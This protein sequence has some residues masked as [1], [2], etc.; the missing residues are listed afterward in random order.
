MFPLRDYSEPEL[1]AL[2]AD[3][4]LLFAD[5]LADGLLVYDAPPAPRAFAP[6][7][8]R[9]L[10]SRAS[11]SQAQLTSALSRVRALRCISH[12]LST[13]SLYPTTDQQHHV[14]RFLWE[15]ANN[16]SFPAAAAATLFQRNVFIISMPAALFDFLTS[17]TW[18]QL[19]HA[20]LFVLAHLAADAHGLDI[21]HEE[22]AP[23]LAAKL[24]GGF[25]SNG[26]SEGCEPHVFRLLLDLVM[27]RIVWMGP[28][29]V[30]TTLCY[31][32]ASDMTDLLAER[33]ERPI[34]STPEKFE[35][36]HTMMWNIYRD[37]QTYH[38]ILVKEGG[39]SR[40]EAL[41]LM[42]RTI[43]K[44]TQSLVD[45]GIR[46][47]LQMTTTEH[48]WD[49]IPFRYEGP[50][51]TYPGPECMYPLPHRLLGMSHLSRVPED[52][53]LRLLLPKLCEAYAS[54]ETLRRRAPISPPVVEANG[55]TPSSVAVPFSLKFWVLEDHNLLRFY[56][57]SDEDGEM[58]DAEA[59]LVEAELV[60][61]GAALE[62]PAPPQAEPGAQPE[63]HRTDGVESVGTQRRRLDEQGSFQVVSSE[64]GSSL[65]GAS[66]VSNTSVS[67][68]S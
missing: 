65:S 50:N 7:R 12:G 66:Y 35:L 39:Y 34:F 60:A 15:A 17:V 47:L 67:D 6:R 43:S 48:S 63:D 28:W 14:N 36:V 2:P 64:G 37:W 32:S 52:V 62:Q 5:E 26:P 27:D 40:L 1:M 53:V 49:D 16:C 11:V 4:R 10:K 31:L 42:A 18:E 21:L 30:P 3:S 25:P 8:R 9:V 24:V 68:L 45:G 22:L 19:E 58:S 20:V 59:E 61:E 46:T 54:D 29:V 38:H 23:T 13:F 56:H 55:D 41:E 51:S 33:Y 44:G 57:E